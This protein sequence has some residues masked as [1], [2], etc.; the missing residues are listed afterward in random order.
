MAVLTYEL[1]QE[2]TPAELAAKVSAMLPGK[3]PVG[4]VVAD[5]N[6]RL[7]IQ[8]MQSTGGAVVT[9]DME[10]EIEPSGTFSTKVTFTVVDGAITA[11]VMS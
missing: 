5:Q 9:D 11:I 3:Q 7:F 2:R 1:V 8:Q 4:Q 10:L 6:G